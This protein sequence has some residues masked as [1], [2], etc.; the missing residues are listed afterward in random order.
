MPHSNL[1]V[2]RNELSAGQFDSAAE[3]YQHLLAENPDDASLYLEL[4]SCLLGLGQLDEALVVAKQA[5]QY[6]VLDFRLHCNV[7]LAIIYLQL[8][9]YELA[10][11]LFQQIMQANPKHVE[12]H[13]GL[14]N[15]YMKTGFP[16]KA[17]EIL[18]RIEHVARDNPRWA[19]NISLALFTMRETNAALDLVLVFLERHPTNIDLIS[20][21]M[22]F[23][24]YTDAHDIYQAML[25]GY[26]KHIYPST[27]TQHHFPNRQKDNPLK[28]GFVSADF[29]WHPVGYFT[30]SFLPHLKALGAELYLYA[31]MG[32]EDSLTQKMRQ[33]SARFTAIRNMTAQAAAELIRADHLDVLIDLS[34]HTAGHRLDIFHQR[35]APVQ[36]SYLGYPESTHLPQMDYVITDRHHVHGDEHHCFSEKVIELPLTRFC[37]MLPMDA[38][39]IAPAPYIA[40]NYL[41]FGSFANPA[42]ISKACAT[43]WGETLRAFPNSRLKLR[44][45]QWDDDGLRSALL[46]ELTDM[47]IAP[48]RIEYY[49]HAK[50]DRYLSAY[51][52]IDLILDTEPFTGGT[53][54][55]EALWMGVPVITWGGTIPANRQG[56]SILHAID[57]TFWIAKDKADVNRIV[58]SVIQSPDLLRDFKSRIRDKIAQSPLGNGK[59]FAKNFYELLRLMIGGQR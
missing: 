37:F 53:T 42:K 39:N 48:G 57:E 30:Q 4:S 35:A 58:Q 50:Y 24:N 17:H 40:N 56:I 12:A 8:E 55:C 33:I 29:R 59:L 21:G 54:T 31:N 11:P 5:L 44:H 49:G 51:A 15:L 2:A 10:G 18:K 20:N 27:N 25:L 52:D 9:R 6:A 7:Q 36:I 41:T 32:S 34:G 45:Q 3:R 28:I 22:M 26:L 16:S 47:G 1:A 23:A 14:A 19:I 46:K 43:I 38:P 13:L